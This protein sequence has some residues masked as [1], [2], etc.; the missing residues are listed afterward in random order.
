MFTFENEDIVMAVSYRRKRDYSKQFVWTYEL[1]EDLYR[2]YQ[3]AREDPRVS[4]MKRMKSYWD[5]SHPELSFFTDKNLRDQ[6]TRVEKRKVVMATEY[7]QREVVEKQGTPT[8]AGILE[9]P[10]E[11]TPGEAVAGVKIIST[12]LEKVTP[13]TQTNTRAN[14]N[15]NDDNPIGTPRESDEYRTI[16]ES[17]ILNYEVLKN[18]PIDERVVTTNTS[19]RIN[20]ALLVII[21][22]ILKEHLEMIS[23]IN[24]WTINVSLYTAAYTIKQYVGELSHDNPAK[25]RDKKEKPKW[26]QKLENSIDNTRKLI[27]KL[28]SVINFK[29]T[30]N[31]T[32]NQQR[33]KEMFKKNTATLNFEHLNT[34]SIY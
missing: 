15:R 32:K 28:S 25:R 17:F 19:K 8:P 24:Y 11:N 20:K 30:N 33:L 16:R 34:S 31:Y 14:E 2:C 7:C 1:N 27:G 18:K 22:E 29:K 10:V 23:E 4:Y 21:N 26:V 3:R 5:E 9:N 12:N 6:A 13:E